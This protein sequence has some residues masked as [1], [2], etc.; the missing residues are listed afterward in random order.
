MLDLLKVPGEHLLLQRLFPPFLS[1]DV[2]LTL[3]FEMTFL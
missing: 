3:F 2:F 1:H